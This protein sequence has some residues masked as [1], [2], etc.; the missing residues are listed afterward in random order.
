MRVVERNG[1]VLWERGCDICS[2][3]VCFSEDVLVTII[4]IVILRVS[5]HLPSKKQQQ[6]QPRLK[7]SKNMSGTF[8]DRDDDDFVSVL[9]Y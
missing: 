5:T 8:Q 6:P 9:L 2:T 1:C 4:R 3:F 7:W